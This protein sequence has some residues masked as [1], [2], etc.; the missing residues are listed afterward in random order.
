MIATTR[1]NLLRDLLRALTLAA[2]AGIGSAV[3][4]GAVVVLLAAAGA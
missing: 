3:A 1:P 4:A 2:A